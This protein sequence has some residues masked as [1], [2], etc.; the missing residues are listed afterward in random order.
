M[1]MYIGSPGSIGSVSAMQAEGTG[2]EYQ[3]GQ[4]FFFI[5]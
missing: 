2:F 3:C 1:Y 4:D 5:L